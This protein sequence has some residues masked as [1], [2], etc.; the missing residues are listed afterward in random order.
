MLYFSISILS[1]SFI[2]LGKAI[3]DFSHEYFYCMTIHEIALRYLLVFKAHRFC[4]L[5][6][7]IV[8]SFALKVFHSQFDFPKHWLTMLTFSIRFLSLD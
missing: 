3:D 7:T 1:Q 5:C 4:T 2:N 8:V 6:P